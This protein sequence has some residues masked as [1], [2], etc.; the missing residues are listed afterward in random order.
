MRARVCVCSGYSMIKQ[1]RSACARACVSVNRRVP[2][3]VVLYRRHKKRQRI[4]AISIKQLQQMFSRLDSDRS[5]LVDTS[6]FAQGFRMPDDLYTAWLLK[7]LDADD[8]GQ[9]YRGSTP[10]TQPTA[11]VKSRPVSTRLVSARTTDVRP[12]SNVYPVL[13]DQTVNGAS[14]HQYP[15]DLKCVPG[16]L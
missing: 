7:M 5:G 8:N 15:T 16:T 13:Y 14:H 11:R 12:T 4:N 9:A 10:L 2:W 6:E 1:S 3:I